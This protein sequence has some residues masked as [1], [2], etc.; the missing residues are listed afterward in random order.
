M[1]KEL[2]ETIDE[3]IIFIC[4]W[5]IESLS[6]ANSNEQCM[7]QNKTIEALA[8]LIIARASIKNIN[9]LVYSSSDDSSKE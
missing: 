2:L 9:E 5:I 6:C 3:T 4:D 8:E 7:H 1:K